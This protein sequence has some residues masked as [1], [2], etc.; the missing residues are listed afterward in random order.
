MTVFND[1]LSTCTQTCMACPTQYEGT[2][3]DGR[4]WYYR[5]R[6]GVAFLGVARTLDQAVDDPL[7]EVE[8]I[9]GPLDGSL[10]EAEFRASF[11]RLALVRLDR[12]GVTR[13][14]WTNPATGR[15]VAHPYERS[16]YS[17]AG[18]C[19]CG[20]VEEH[21]LHVADADPPGVVP[22]DELTEETP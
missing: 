14:R 4:H 8:F 1:L 2:L 11:M 3:H 5:Y 13:Q 17:G 10:T 19:W 6:H 21:R 9:G 15:I 22:A 18:N 12:D 20:R 7:G 16:P